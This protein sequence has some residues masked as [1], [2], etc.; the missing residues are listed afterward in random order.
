MFE[1]KMNDSPPSNIQKTMINYLALIPADLFTLICSYLSMN[2][3]FSKFHVL[4]RSIRKMYIPAK[5]CCNDSMIIRQSNFDA[6]SSSLIFNQLLNVIQTLDLSFGSQ[7]KEQISESLVP[8]SVAFAILDGNLK[9]LKLRE[10]NSEDVHGIEELIFYVSK[11]M[12]AQNP[13]TYN[14]TQMK[15][16]EL[17]VV[18]QISTRKIDFS[19]FFGQNLHTLDINTPWLREVVYENDKTIFNQLQ[20]LPPS[21]TFLRMAHDSGDP[22][23]VDMHPVLFSNPLWLPNIQ[24]FEIGHDSWN[25]IEIPLG[26]HLSTIMKSTSKVRPYEWIQLVLSDNSINSFS[27]SFL[28]VTHLT[29]RIDWLHQ[30]WLPFDAS[31]SVSMPHLKSFKFLGDGDGIGDDL[32]VDINPMII[33]LSQRPLENLE[34]SLPR[35]H[36]WFVPITDI[37]LNGLNNMHNLISLEIQID[38]SILS[39]DTIVRSIKPCCWPVLKT[40]MLSDLCLSLEAQGSFFLAAPKVENINI[41]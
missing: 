5:H 20:A 12:I 31:D 16:S 7:S 19:C 14:Q 2:T 25:A 30:E 3:K 37:A 38:S 39:N 22:R 1:A 11:F 21:L 4:N 17:F 34:L 10:M 26:P 6:I 27:H 24:H 36:E 28:N 9:N 29:I 23:L 40:L 8:I 41:I 18:I 33:F 35:G 32:L 15:L 13:I